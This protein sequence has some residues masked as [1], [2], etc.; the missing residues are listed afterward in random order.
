MSESDYQELVRAAASDAAVLGLILTGSRGRRV[1]VQPDSDWDVRLIVR[2]QA[3]EE[4]AARFGT[5][6]GSPVEVVVLSLSGFEQAGAL[7]TPNE[8]D[9]YSYAHAQV[10]L[11]KLV[12]GIAKPCKTTSGP[13]AS[14]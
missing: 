8:W 9:R 11:D 5:P 10:V 1:F 14:P 13:Q 3:R 4:Y 12:G 7:G 2:D 6:R